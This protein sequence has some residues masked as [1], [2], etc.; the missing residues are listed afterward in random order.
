[1]INR[2]MLK[3]KVDLLTDE[4]VVEVIEYISIME[5]V[6]AQVCTPDPLEEALLGFL[7]QSM[8]ADSMSPIGRLRQRSLAN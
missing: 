6:R 3:L 5:S 1:M 7:I 2:Q 4:E 8:R